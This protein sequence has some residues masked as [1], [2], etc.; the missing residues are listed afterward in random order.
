M[1]FQ[2]NTSH[3]LKRVSRDKM[4]Q[5]TKQPFKIF[6]TEQQLVLRYLI[7]GENSQLVL[8][9]LIFAT[10]KTTISPVPSYLQQRK[11]SPVLPHI[12]NR[13]NYN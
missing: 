11:L 7:F 13:E 8:R 12:C 6:A 5:T 4:M 3:T 2:D 9:Y 10:E 1:Y